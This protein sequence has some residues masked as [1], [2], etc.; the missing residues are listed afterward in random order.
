MIFNNTI[1]VP[2][3]KSTSMIMLDEYCARVDDPNGHCVEN[4]APATSVPLKDQIGRGQD[5]ITPPLN[6]DGYQASEP[7]LIWNNLYS[8]GTRILVSPLDD[9]GFGNSCGTPALSDYIRADVDY[10]LGTGPESTVMPTS[11]NG[12]SVTYTPYTYP[13]PLQGR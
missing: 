12:L 2:V 9:T 7:Y 5:I 10:C 4:C 1:S 3:T 11:C 8:D 6:G 13:H